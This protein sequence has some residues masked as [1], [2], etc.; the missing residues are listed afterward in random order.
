MTVKLSFC[1]LLLSAPDWMCSLPRFEGFA[2]SNSIHHETPELLVDHRPLTIENQGLSRF[3]LF[4][5][6]SVQK[7]RRAIVCFIQWAQS[8]QRYRRTMA[9]GC[10]RFLPDLVKARFPTAGKHV[11]L[12]LHR[13]QNATWL[14]N[15]TI[16]K[17]S[18]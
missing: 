11:L 17:P 1:C 2:S 4:S 15:Q 7:A 6:C 16:Y 10:S 13:G 14:L 12:Q 18:Q 3:P 5:F 8:G 9:T